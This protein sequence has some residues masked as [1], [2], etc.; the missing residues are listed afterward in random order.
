M[1]ESGPVIL[2]VDL[3]TS[4]L[5]VALVGAD[6]RLLAEARRA[7]PTE[8]D[9][10][11]HAAEQRPAEWSR[12]L[13]EAVLADLAAAPGR[14]SIAAIC[15]VGQGPTMVAV[16][17]RGA[18]THPAIT[19]LDGRPASEAS[20]LELA[21]GLAG[22]SLGIL[23]AA[24]W[25]ER[26]DPAA[27]ARTR[28]YLN[29]WEWGALSLAEVAAATRSLGQV[30]A[31]RD[32][33]AATGL[34][35]QRL[36]PVVET[37]TIVGGLTPRAAAELG[38][39][40][41]IPVVAGTNDAFA[42]FLGAGLLERGD[43]I[44]TGG[45][46]GG[47]AVYWDAQVDVPGSWVAPAPIAGRWLVGGAMTATGR[48]LDWLADDV[49]GGV[50]VETLIAEAAAVRP[51]CDGL[52]F[53]P[54]LAGER[55]PLWDPEAR[56]AFVGLTLVHGRGH[57][58]RAV[59]EAAAYALRHVAAPIR[60]AGLGIDRLVV[61]GGTARSEEW[62]RIKADVIGVPVDVPEVRET[63]LLGA[64]MLGAVAV[65]LHSD[66]PAAIRA[67]ARVDHR[68]EPDPATAAAYDAGFERYT[69]VW[70]AIAPIV[71]RL[72]EERGPG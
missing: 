56:G 49:L 9:P 70:P 27:A 52:V 66:L 23:P 22:W 25:L 44:D 55:S 24:R 15:V 43:A 14:S 31:D 61:T 72:G 33:L 63:A 3:G 36:P 16:D 41:G 39:A 13:T 11:T 64:A 58:A 50:P 51:G 2:A 69:A 62:N 26:H 48:A 6:G 4:E 34:A 8:V 19:W 38:L 30:V 54:Y 59:L 28:W 65:G 7:Y 42:S 32:R 10:A 68:L 53:L 67:I 60:A 18:A 21:T 20:E 57:L 29:A 46:S 40:K 17:G 1:T 12:A 35:V 37:G 47:L 71:H 5:K 45:T